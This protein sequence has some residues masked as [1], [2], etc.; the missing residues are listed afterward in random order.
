MTIRRTSSSVAALL[1]ELELRQPSVVTAALVEALI[2]DAG[3]D[4]AVDAAIERLVRGG[5]LSPLRTRNAWEFVP[6]A[7]AGRFASGDPWIELRAVLERA[8]KAP[9]AV[10]F[11]S[12]LWTLGF[13]QHQPSVP[14]FAHRS[15]W[16]PPRSLD[17]VRS[18]RFDWKIT[19]AKRDRLPVWQPAT[20]L[21][22]AACRPECQGNWGNA[23]EWLSDLVNAAGSDDVL[24]EA[25]GLGAARI[26]RLGYLAEW[27]GNDRL[28]NDVERLLGVARPVV[29]FGPR[30]PRGR[31]AN[32]WGL[33]DSM[34]PAR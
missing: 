23:D 1:Q 13:S 25:M 22:A 14:V 24:S 28:A 5:W 6:A 29:Y 15:G 8:P 21:V 27:A 20:I 33:Y 12:A 18:V 11:D 30:Q 32:R 16:R 7:R 3:S 2:A 26:A 9:V 34:L 19:A 4:L 10:A 17:H 31:W